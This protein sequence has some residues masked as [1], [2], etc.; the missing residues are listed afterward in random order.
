ML[1]ACVWCSADRV[2]PRN[3]AAGDRGLGETLFVV[4]LHSEAHCVY[5]VFCSAGSVWC[6]TLNAV[7]F[8]VVWP[9]PPSNAMPF[10]A[11]SCMLTRS[12]LLPCLF[13]CNRGYLHGTRMK[14]LPLTRLPN[15]RVCEWC[16]SCVSVASPVRSLLG[17]HAFAL[18][19]CGLSRTLRSLVV[20]TSS[21]K[22]HCNVLLEF[23]LQHNQHQ[24]VISIAPPCHLWCLFASARKFNR[25]LVV[26]LAHRLLFCGLGFTNLFGV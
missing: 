14:V 20:L 15:C 19:L 22:W 7:W 9:A 5:N 3:D 16:P 8:N 6:S 12:L 10:P 2:E 4:P 24:H 25:G 18:S 1:P 23:T 21:T 11:C 17:T 13:P 26:C